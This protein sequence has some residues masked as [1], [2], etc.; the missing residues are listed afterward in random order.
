MRLAGGCLKTSG[1]RVF[2]NKWDEVGSSVAIG[3]C[4][5]YVGGN[6]CIV[7]ASIM[8]RRYRD[9]RIPDL[10][11]PDQPVPNLLMGCQA[12]RNLC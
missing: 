10:S 1:M 5:Q 11:C 8:R 6:Y 12:L 7:V 9:C 4:V 3:N 2:E